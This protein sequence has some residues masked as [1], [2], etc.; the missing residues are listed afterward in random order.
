MTVYSTCKR[1]MQHGTH[2]DPPGQQQAQLPQ[3]RMRLRVAWRM[4][5]F[6]KII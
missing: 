4:A 1:F 2:H 6:K 5:A 3:P